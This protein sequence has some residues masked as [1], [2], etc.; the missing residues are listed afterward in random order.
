MRPV[1][2]HTARLELSAPTLEDVGRITEY[3]QDPLF[4][5]FL[6]TPWPYTREHGV[7]FVTEYV[8]NGWRDDREFTWAMRVNGD[9]VGCIGLRH[10]DSGAVNLGYWVGAPHRRRGYLGEAMDAVLDWGFARGMDRI[11]WEA[12]VGNTA[13]AASARSRGFR[14]DGIAPGADGT[15]SWHAHLTV[16]DDRAPQPGWPD[17]TFPPT[18]AAGVGNS[19][20]AADDSGTDR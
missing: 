17:D 7:S 8:A 9:L 1:V 2:L 13:S 10:E 14:Y 16:V 3:C 4:E 15:P 20:V 11:R 6:T 5:R 19:G 12:V 18:S